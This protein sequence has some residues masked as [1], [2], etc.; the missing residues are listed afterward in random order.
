MP[1]FVIVLGNVRKNTG[2][3]NSN[4]IQLYNYYKNLFIIFP[5][6]RIYSTDW[7]QNS[8]ASSTSTATISRALDIRDIIDDPTITGMRIDRETNTFYFTVPT[9]GYDGIHQLNYKP[10][11]NYYDASTNDISN[12]RWIAIG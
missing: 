6:E 11:K 2:W 9:N 10:N 12:Y 8:Y 3:R 5:E 4:G 1:K 7:Y